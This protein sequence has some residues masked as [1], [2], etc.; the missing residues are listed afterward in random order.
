MKQSPYRTQSDQHA[1]VIYRHTVC[2]KL[3]KL[4]KNESI[5]SVSTVAGRL[6][7]FSLT[8]R[9]PA[10]SA[11]ITWPE[12]NTSW[13]EALAA[14]AGRS[15]PDGLET[16]RQRDAD[17]LSS[18]TLIIQ[19]IFVLLVVKCVYLF[20]VRSRPHVS[21]LQSEQK[22]QLSLLI[23]QLEMILLVIG[24]FSLIPSTS[25]YFIIIIKLQHCEISCFFPDNCNYSPLSEGHELFRN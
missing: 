6:N 19:V 9:H 17:I 18:W 14:A 2:T 15:T 11:A 3:P 16:H 12:L 21:V 5:K 20:S 4:T 8:V 23:G 1:S 25:V 24:R 7:G 22:H 10:V 13:F